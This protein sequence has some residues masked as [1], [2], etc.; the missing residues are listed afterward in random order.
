MFEIRRNRA[1]P[2]YKQ[3]IFTIKLSTVYTN[4]IHKSSLYEYSTVQCSVYAQ[5]VLPIVFFI[6]YMEDITKKSTD[7]NSKELY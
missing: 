6:F 2:E 3:Q 7:G 1:L 5:T 4:V